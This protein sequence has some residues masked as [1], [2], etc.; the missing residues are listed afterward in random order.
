MRL[1]EVNVLI[2]QGQIS[3]PDF[4]N[5]ADTIPENNTVFLSI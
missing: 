4:L 5:I 1:T 3:V 2:S